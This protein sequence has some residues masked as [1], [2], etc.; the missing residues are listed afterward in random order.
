[1]SNFPSLEEI[2]E[3][4]V[5]T[6]TPSE[7]QNDDFLA[8]EKAVLGEDAEAFTSTDGPGADEA[9]I[10]FETSFPP[11]ESVSICGSLYLILGGCR[12]IV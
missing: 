7:F 3:G 10:G 8:R 4:L 5:S 11:L 1:M 2:D 9:V 6:E 12:L